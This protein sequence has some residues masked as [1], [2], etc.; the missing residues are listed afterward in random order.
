MI[1]FG[2]VLNMETGF[3]G[4]ETKQ[5]PGFQMPALIWLK[6]STSIHEP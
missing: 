5:N 1:V 3:Q 4:V 6:N 2:P